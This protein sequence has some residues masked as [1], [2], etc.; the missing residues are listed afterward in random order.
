M[1]GN[2]RNEIA[3]SKQI[4][5]TMPPIKSSSFGREP[6]SISAPTRLHM[7]RR[8]YSWRGE[9]I[10]DRESVTIP[11][12]VESKPDVERAFNCH[13]T[14]GTLELRVLTPQSVRDAAVN[15]SDRQ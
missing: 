12:K 4:H 6:L 3:F 11:T 14:P 10:K 9:D 7:T 5:R 1:V 8:T 15:G 2:F 13:E